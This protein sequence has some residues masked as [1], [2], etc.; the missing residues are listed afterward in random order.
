MNS[1]I[2]IHDIPPVYNVFTSSFCT[3]VRRGSFCFLRTALH[4]FSLYVIHCKLEILLSR[5]SLLILSTTNL[6]FVWGLLRNVSATSLCV[7]IGYDLD[8]PS[9]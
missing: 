3:G 8:F 4:E 6:L 2:L 1:V 5:L 7:S 9:S